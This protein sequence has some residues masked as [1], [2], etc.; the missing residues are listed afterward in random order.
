MTVPEAVVE[1]RLSNVG[2]MPITVC[3]TDGDG[4]AILA[5]TV[6]GKQFPVSLLLAGAVS[7]APCWE[8][9]MLKPGETK[10]FYESVLLS[11]A[12]NPLIGVFGYIRL[13]SD[14]RERGRQ[15]STELES[16]PIAIPERRYSPCP[17]SMSGV[18]SGLLT[19]FPGGPVSEE[20]RYLMSD[21]ATVVV[22]S[23]AGGAFYIPCVYPSSQYRVCVGPP[24]S[25][26][27]FTIAGPVSG[28]PPLIVR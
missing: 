15:W 18:V 13:H 17:S 22:K 4:V 3:Q 28:F 11:D 19:K 24:D 21:D 1:A 6:D 5:R 20:V 7:D 9:T 2:L 8:R 12:K 26:Q 27:C 23:D 25:E 14:P 10:V 16:P